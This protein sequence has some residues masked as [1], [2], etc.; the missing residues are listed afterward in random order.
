MDDE[1]TGYVFIKIARQQ[2][3]TSYDTTSYTQYP[4]LDLHQ[5]KSTQRFLLIQPVKASRLVD[6]RFTSSPQQH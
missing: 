1:I 6:L 3:M 2:D 4:R 5:H